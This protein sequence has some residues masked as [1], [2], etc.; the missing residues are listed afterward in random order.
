MEPI[1]FHLHVQHF[2]VFF[3]FPPRPIPWVWHPVSGEWASM[4]CPIHQIHPC[5]PFSFF[6]H[7]VSR[8]GALEYPYRRSSSTP[9]TNHF[10]SKEPNRNPRKNRVCIIQQ[11][12]CKNEIRKRK[13][14]SPR[15]LNLIDSY[16]CKWQC[17]LATS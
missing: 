7:F 1:C 2:F 10:Y 14:F 9:G 11:I 12:K 3:T 13:Y 16:G 15:P 6:R 8:Y 4:N 17:S 5:V